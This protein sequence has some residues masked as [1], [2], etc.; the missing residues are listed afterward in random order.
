ML[1]RRDRGDANDRAAIVHLMTRSDAVC[2]VL[3]H[4][5][6]PMVG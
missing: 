3:V 5:A 6:P 1:V 2:R 4:A